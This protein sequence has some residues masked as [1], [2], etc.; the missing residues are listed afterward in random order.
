MAVVALKST[1]LTN[2]DST[3][4]KLNRA[5]VARARRLHNRGVVT[6]GA[7][8]SIGS[9]YRFTR[10]KSSDMILSVL[11]D[12]DAIATAPTMDIGL[13]RTTRD[14]GAV[15]NATLF[16]SAVAL[17]AAQASLNVTRES[18]VIT[19]ANME[20]R[21]WE[22]LALTEDPLLEYDVTGTLVAATTAVGSIAVAVD[23]VG[24]S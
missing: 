13:Y 11:L 22:L 24:G 15:V 5:D 7:A 18:L 20:K 1:P 8:D 9:T 14:G 3:P 17:A 16:A 23:V 6:T 2:A 21:V 19:V 10:I 12:N 4:V